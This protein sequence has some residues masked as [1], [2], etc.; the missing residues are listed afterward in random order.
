MEVEQMSELVPK[1]KGYRLI[2]NGE[3]A[4]GTKIEVADRIEKNGES[5]LL[6]IAMHVLNT[7]LEGDEVNIRC[8]EIQ[9]ENGKGCACEIIRSRPPPLSN[10]TFKET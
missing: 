9:T 1:A 7:Q 5:F 8:T 2:E 4:K 3:Y 10:T 6:E